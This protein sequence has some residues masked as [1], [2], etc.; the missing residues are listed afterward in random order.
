MRTVFEI[1]TNIGFFVNIYWIGLAI[2]NG[3]IINRVCPVQIFHAV[4]W[5]FATFSI[6]YKWVW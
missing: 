5:L 1:I 2:L 4:I 6:C 3:T